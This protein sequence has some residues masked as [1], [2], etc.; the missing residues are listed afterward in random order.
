MAR[1]A[2]MLI[3]GGEACSDAIRAGR[4]RLVLLAANA[5]PSTIRQAEKSLTGHRALLQTLPFEKDD[6][7]GLLG[8]QSCS[9]LCLTDAGFAAAFSRAMAE[10]YP[11]WGETADTLEQRAEK[12]KR[13]KAAPRKHPQSGKRRT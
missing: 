8:K 1:K 6:L 13:R 7:S 5:A 12:A 2:G 9:L 11:E 3:P 4:A 10:E